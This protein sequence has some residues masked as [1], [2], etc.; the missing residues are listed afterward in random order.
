MAFQL[1]C[2]DYLYL[3]Y[4]GKEESWGYIAP[5]YLYW[6]LDEARKAGLVLYEFLN[7]PL[8]PIYVS[9]NRL[10][11]A[12]EI[13]SRCEQDY[14]KD[15]GEESFETNLICSLYR[16]LIR[17]MEK[18]NLGEI[19]FVFHVHRTGPF[20][21]LIINSKVYT[22][23]RKPSEDDLIS[24]NAISWYVDYYEEIINWIKKILS[25]ELGIK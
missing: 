18:Y 15:Y 16:R 19:G 8:V 25:K 22:Y 9:R 3:V 20:A 2:S 12:I 4:P 7:G 14:Y 10:N 5:T 24:S 6:I 1:S 13:I 23:G 11:E 17:L 21:L